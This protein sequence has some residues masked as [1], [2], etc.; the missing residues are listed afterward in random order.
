M[1]HNQLLPVNVIVNNKCAACIIDFGVLEK[2]DPGLHH[3][4]R[5]LELPT[6]LP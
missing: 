1:T 3:K 4:G 2:L 6:S 5:F